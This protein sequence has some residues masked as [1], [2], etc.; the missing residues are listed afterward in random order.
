M[1]KI[2]GKILSLFRGH[3]EAGMATAEYAVGTVAVVGIGS[4]I[5][6][7]I[8][9]P[10]FREAIWNVILWILRLITGIAG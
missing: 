9:D 4:I 10:I 6:K 3:R 2:I 5:Y 7:I 1:K 8:S